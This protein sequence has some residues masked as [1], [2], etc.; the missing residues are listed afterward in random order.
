MLFHI[1][2][3]IILCNGNDN[4]KNNRYGQLFVFSFH[5]RANGCKSGAHMYFDKSMATFKMYFE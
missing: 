3:E 1:D 4:V 5:L 2:A